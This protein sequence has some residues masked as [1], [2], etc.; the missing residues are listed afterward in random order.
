M[1][2]APALSES[3]FVL[4]IVLIALVPL[5]A[6]GLALINTGLGRS[7]SAAHTM[8]TSL[9]VLA[10]AAVTYLVLG[11]AWQGT[12]GGPA[13]SLIIR[14]TAWNWIAAQP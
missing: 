13:H 14:G 8:L 6:L 5:A 2:S 12:A 10:V 1:T 7:R 3:S 9:C 4:C 11:F